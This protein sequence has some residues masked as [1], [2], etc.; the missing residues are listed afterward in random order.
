MRSFQK[1]CSHCGEKANT[2]LIKDNNYDLVDIFK[3]NYCN[4][5]A[6]LHDKKCTNCTNIFTGVFNKCENCYGIFNLNDY[7]CNCGY[8]KDKTQKTSSNFSEKI[9]PYRKEKLKS[10]ARP[11]LFYSLLLVFF[12]FYF[13]MISI[14]FSIIILKIFRVIKQ[15]SKKMI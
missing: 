14:F 1:K 8:K 11:V 10:Y 3:C 2:E 7:S 6:L 12:N 4:T 13:A 9:K 15:Q 5:I